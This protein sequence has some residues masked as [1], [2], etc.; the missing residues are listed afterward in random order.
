MNR[1]IK[2]F[3]CMSLGHIIFQYLNKQVIIM[4]DNREVM[5][6][7]E[8]VNDAMLKL[9]NASDEEEVEYPIEGESLVAKHS[10]NTQIKV[11]DMK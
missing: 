3:K 11:D 4:H 7:N 9:V 6:D 5:T 1:D 8:N 2:Y 10:L